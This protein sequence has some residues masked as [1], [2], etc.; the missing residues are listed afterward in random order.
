MKPFPHYNR[1]LKEYA[2]ELRNHSTKSEILIW[3][4][5][6]R[7]RKTG[8][9]CQRQRPI[10]RYIVDFFFPEV[11]LILEID[12]YSH[13]FEEKIESDKIRDE[14]L[15]GLGYKTLRI[16]DQQVFEEMENAIATIE[17]ALEN[18][19]LELGLD[20]PVRKIRRKAKD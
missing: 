6:L 14:R 15:L 20:Q 3:S 1:Y 2:R 18:R 11:R 16:S 5:A 8:Y 4:V 10:D 13:S 7:N 12:G 17:F 19:R 9:Q